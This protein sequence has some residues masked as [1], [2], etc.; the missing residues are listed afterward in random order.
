MVADGCQRRQR[1]RRA[2][3]MAHA[4]LDARIGEHGLLASRESYAAYLGATW[5][6]RR[7][8]ELA[9]EESQAA[10]IYRVWR[11]R[12]ASC[13][14]SQ[15]IADLSGQLPVDPPR[16][17]WRSTPLT[18]LGLAERTAQGWVIT[19]PGSAWLAAHDL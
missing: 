15:D 6:A 17:D 16:E 1:L 14:L 4:R 13:D 7:P 19:P 8:V 18:E 3:Q 5:T 11:E 9:L 10:D 2:T 12:S